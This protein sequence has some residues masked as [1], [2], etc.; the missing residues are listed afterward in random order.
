MKRLT[1]AAD[2]IIYR[3]GEAAEHA[4]LLLE[5]EVLMERGGIEVRVKPRSLLGFSGLFGRPYGSTTR[6][7]VACSVVEFTRKELRALVRSNPEEAL[8]LIEAMMDLLGQ[9]SEALE[10]RNMT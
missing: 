6:A 1:V 10:R 4:Y 5:G 3:Q 9:V 2:E 7:V 8:Q